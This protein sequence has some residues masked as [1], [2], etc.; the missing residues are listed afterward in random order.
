MGKALPQ[1]DTSFGN[2]AH[3]DVAPWSAGEIRIEHVRSGEGG[4]LASTKPG[5]VQL[6]R[7]R[8]LSIH[9]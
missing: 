9:A 4:Q 3:A 5:P 2:E 1:M 7:D 8:G 6:Q